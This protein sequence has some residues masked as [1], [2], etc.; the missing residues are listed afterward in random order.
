MYSKFIPTAAPTRS[1][2]DWLANS[3]AT[4]TEPAP[5]KEQDSAD[6]GQA[7]QL[8]ATYRKLIK[9]AEIQKQPRKKK[10]YGR[11]LQQLLSGLNAVRTDEGLAP[12]KK[13]PPP[14]HRAAAI[15]INPAV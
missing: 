11:L 1:P 6:E 2:T 9:I 12:V 14:E 8:I 7:K 3:I 4:N 13:Q 15:S 10:K 5:R